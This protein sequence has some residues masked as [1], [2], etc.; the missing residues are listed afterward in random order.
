MHSLPRC[1]S[2]PAALL[3]RHGRRPG[4]VGVGK[5]IETAFVFPETCHFDQKAKSLLLYFLIIVL[6]KAN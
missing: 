3:G 4:R 6:L 5:S 1:L 2:L